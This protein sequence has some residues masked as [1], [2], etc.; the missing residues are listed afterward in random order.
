M[1]TLGTIG[2]AISTLTVHPTA[3]IAPVLVLVLAV[4]SEAA[5]S[6]PQFG[7]MHRYLPTQV[8]DVVRRAARPPVATSD[9]LH[10]LLSSG[11][12]AVIFCPIAWARFTS[13]DVTARRAARRR[14][15]SVREDWRITSCGGRALPR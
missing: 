7:A 14:T 9:L 8:V 2:L 15:C 1:A 4:A 3:A 11:A 13:A 12:Y 6:I 5:G 10:V